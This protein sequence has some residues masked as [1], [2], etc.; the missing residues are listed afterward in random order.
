M[1]TVFTLHIPYV[2]SS[3]A[4]MRTYELLTK[5]T[6]TTLLSSLARYKKDNPNATDQ[7]AAQKVLKTDVPATVAG[8]PAYFKKNLN[9][10]VAIVHAKGLPHLFLTLT[11]D[12]VSSTK[13][14]EVV[15]L[16]ERLKRFNDS[17][18]WQDAPVECAQLF[19]KR[20]NTFMKEVL[21]EQ[22]VLGKIDHFVMRLEVQGRGSLHA[23]IMLWVAEEDVNRVTDEIVA[24]VPALWNE[25]DNYMVS[26]K[27]RLDMDAVGM[28]TMGGHVYE[29]QQP[30][31]VRFTHYH[32]THNLEG[33]CYQLLLQNVPFRNEG[34]L[35]GGDGTYLTGCMNHNVLTSLA[36]LQT[37]V[38]DH[39]S[40]F[41]WNDANVSDLVNSIVNKV[42]PEQHRRL[43]LDVTAADDEEL[44]PVSEYDDAELE[45]LA[46]AMFDQPNPVDQTSDAPNTAVTM[47]DMSTEPWWDAMLQCQLTPD[48]QAAIDAI[49]SQPKPRGLKI[50][51]GDPG[52]GKSFLTRHIARRAVAAGL[53]VLPC[54]STGAAAVRLSTVAQTVH[55]TFAIRP[56]RLG[57]VF[58]STLCVSDPRAQV[59]YMGDVILIDEFSQLSAPLINQVLQRLQTLHRASSVEDLLRRVLIV[60]VGDA[61]QLP[62]V[63]HCKHDGPIC[64]KCRITASVA[65]Q[66][67]QVIELTSNFRAAADP[68]LCEFQATARTQTVTQEYI[69]QVFAERYIDASDVDALLTSDARAICSHQQEVDHY[70]DLS[71]HK[72]FAADDIQ[73]VPMLATSRTTNAPLPEASYAKAAKGFHLL[74]E[75]AIGAPVRITSNIDLTKGAANGAIGVV[76]AWLVLRHPPRCWG[77][78]GNI[79][80]TMYITFCTTSACV[81]HALGTSTNRSATA[82]GFVHASMPF[83]YLPHHVFPSS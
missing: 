74:S 45:Q 57:T 62:A 53:N 22:Q 31:V 4:L 73:A 80:L 41:L 70:N 65:W 75:V 67:A 76:T 12:E 42:T 63:C 36:D 49:L 40:A 56:K 60:F 27:P 52:C 24:V 11:A 1:F 8:S 68:V 47:P 23:H 66:H 77:Q 26:D 55:T 37:A 3:Y 29:L 20:V 7:Q 34:D 14:S 72:H 13:W 69:D 25:E 82:F 39:C 19:C 33:F 15:Q 83:T 71:L 48:Q 51:T 21:V 32:P 81:R 6:A 10:L 5:S 38:N 35:R 79:S 18:T 9:D 17:Y 78:D 58:E 30:R 54:A 50:L 28:D 2:L 64:Q 16:E 59:L 46:H 44:E 43:H 61:H